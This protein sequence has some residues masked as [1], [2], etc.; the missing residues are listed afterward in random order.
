MFEKTSKTAP[1]ATN[2]MPTEKK[3]GKTVLAVR[4]GCHAGKRCCFNAVSLFSFN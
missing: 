4:T 3:R 1:S 2:K